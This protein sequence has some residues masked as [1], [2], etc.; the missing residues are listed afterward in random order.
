LKTVLFISH[1]QKQCGIYQYGQMTYDALKASKRYRFVYGE[2]MSGH[3]FYRLVDSILGIGRQE[4]IAAVIFN[5][6]PPLASWLTAPVCEAI[7]WPLAMIA[8]DSCCPYACVKWHIHVDPTHGECNGHFSVCRPIPHYVCT[9]KPPEDLTVGTFGFGLNFNA[10]RRLVQMVAKQFNEAVIRIHMP[11]AHYGDVDGK[12]AMARVEEARM[13]LRAGIK[14]E[15]SHDF[16]EP[17]QLLDWLAGNTINVFLYDT[18]YGRG[19]ASVTDFALAVPRP[20]ALT[21]SWQFRHIPE[22]FNRVEDYELP[23]IL[24]LNPLT[25]S[26]RSFLGIKWSPELL[27]KQ[28]EGIV[29]DILE[30]K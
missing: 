24:K 1:R 25:S 23:R 15:V 20:L 26:Q 10:Q 29:D 3:E 17:P 27:C 13:S 5:F 8:H 9:I 22:L 19:P 6:G 30:A 18:N 28:Y 21:R 16:L 2:A 14:L 12:Q 4:D 7:P 11:F